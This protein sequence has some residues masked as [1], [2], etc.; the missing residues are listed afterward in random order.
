MK[1]DNL[2]FPKKAYVNKFIPKNKF[3]GKAALSS[4]LQ[5]E[6]KGLVSRG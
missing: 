6:L 3:Y 5:K 4:K 1:P 2:K